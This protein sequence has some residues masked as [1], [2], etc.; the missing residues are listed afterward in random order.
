MKSEYKILVL[1]PATLRPKILEKTLHSF[2]TK[3]FN[4]CPEKVTFQIAIHIDPVGDS[5]S[6]MLD[7]DFITSRY[8]DVYSMY[9]NYQTPCRF[10]IAFW[11]LWWKADNSESFDYFFYLEDDWVLLNRVDPI[12]MIEV[13]ENNPN[14][15]SLRLPYKALNKTYSKNWSHQFPWNDDYFQCE[16][17]DKEHIGWCG[18]PNMVR[19]E[20][21]HETFP[22]LSKKYCP[23]K[24]MKGFYKN[25]PVAGFPQLSKM[26]EVIM[27]WDYGVFGYPNEPA[28]VMDI[29]R[30]WRV[31]NGIK[32]NGDTSWVRRNK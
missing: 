24:Q 3:M 8:M 6:T 2:T 23:E 15:A 12:R 21:I 30:K 16:E 4:H 9:K 28:Y 26:A 17:K 32:K 13:M 27:K 19:W 1:M 22:H 18:H 7:T 5:D 25:T 29:G 14:L 10:A 31:E 11:H 20:F